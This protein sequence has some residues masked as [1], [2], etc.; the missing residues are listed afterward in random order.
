MELIVALDVENIADAVSLVNTL[1][2]KVKVF[3]V[4]SK[5]FT[6]QGPALIDFINSRGAKVFLDLKYHDIPSVVAS[7]VRIA[8]LKGVFA[9]SIHLSGGR[10]MLRAASLAAPKP[11]LWGISVL[12]SLT[13]DDL[14]TINVNKSVGEQVWALSI[15][16]R[17][18]KL[19]GVVCSCHEIHIVREVGGLQTIVPG[20]RM[21]TSGDDQKRTLTPKAA[22]E[23]GADYIVM[24]RPIISSKNPSEE[25]DKIFEQIK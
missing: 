8:A 20:V 25:V 12:T 10:E 24:G 2:D 9:T 16:A 19:D 14:K 15:I 6:A 1:K 5:L 13:G 22:K 18:E 4:G 17:E 3:K 7:A 23:L 21:T 11:L